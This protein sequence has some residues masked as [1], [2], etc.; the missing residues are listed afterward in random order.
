VLL[1]Q[2]PAPVFISF[3]ASPVVGEQVTFVYSSTG[4]TASIDWDLDGDG[5]FDDAHG[6]SATRT[7]PAPGTYQVGLR[8]T[9]L[10]GLVST[11]T[12]T[13]T[14]R[15]PNPSRV[16]GPIVP[17]TSYPKL[18]APFP[19]VRISGRTAPGG[20]HITLLEVIA[21][22][23]AKVSVHCAGKSCPFHRWRRIVGSKRLIVKPLRGRFLRAGVK[24]EVRV[25]KQ[26][27][28][29][30][31]TRIVIRRHKAP[32]RRDLCL[33]PGSSKASACPST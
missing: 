22:A 18:M 1:N 5:E 11:S 2:A 17:A 25:Y 33:P 28:I 31:Y 29:G 12:R 10:D 24:L 8:V 9:D 27:V 6:P 20:A 30:K 19:I 15:L 16:I 23:G 32:A 14:V 13:I 7:F 3:P 21:P 4:G 26:G